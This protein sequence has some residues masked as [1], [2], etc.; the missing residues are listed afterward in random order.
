MRIREFQAP[1]HETPISEIM[2]DILDLIQP[3][4]GNES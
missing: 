4:L 1:E 3:S 2:K